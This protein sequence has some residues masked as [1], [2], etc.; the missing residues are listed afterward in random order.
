M[1]KELSK[2]LTDS[3]MSTT[4]KD[5]KRYIKEN[6]AYVDKPIETKTEKNMEKIILIIYA[7]INNIDDC[8]VPEYL[9]ELSNSLKAD[10]DE[11]IKYICIPIRKG[12]GRIE[13]INPKL[14]T[15]EDYSK[16][17]NTIKEFEERMSNF[18]N[19]N[20]FEKETVKISFNQEYEKINDEILNIREK[21]QEHMS[22]TLIM[23]KKYV[24]N[25][26]LELESL[27]GKKIDL[28]N[29]HN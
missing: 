4:E 13:C 20:N 5:I 10:E 25:K 23:D 2:E 16:V 3:I 19:N 9:E 21:I 12:D 8:D 1:K 22:S 18:F 26:M 17:K 6:D 14:V 7:N 15:G 29:Y 28:L 24:F 27:I 11:N